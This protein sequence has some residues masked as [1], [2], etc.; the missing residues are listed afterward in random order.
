MP[1]VAKLLHEIR[2]MPTRRRLWARL[3]DYVHS[4]GVAMASYH[5]VAADGTTLPIATDGFPEGWVREYLARGYVAIDPIPELAARLAEPFYWHD[6]EALAP[7]R[8]AAA[9]YLA[10]MEAAALGD[11]LAFYVFGPALQ[12]AYVGLGFGEARVELSADDV[13]ELQCVIQA[14]HLRYCA[15]DRRQTGSAPLSDREREVL[16]WVARG[17]SNSVIGDIL[18]I[19]AHTVDAHMRAI[20]RKLGVADRTSAALRGVGTGIIRLR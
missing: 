13:F 4:K 20:Y 10:A 19:S 16:E 12:N 3:L 1:A 11:G 15:L 8:P 2:E 18:E 6:I 9:R 7:D 5:A 14:G 17:K